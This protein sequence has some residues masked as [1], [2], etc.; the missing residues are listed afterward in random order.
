MKHEEMI[1]NAQEC[2]DNISPEDFLDEYLS[3]QHDYDGVGI[4]VSELLG[5]KDERQEVLRYLKSK[6]KVVEEVL[7]AHCETY[8]EWSN[9]LKY[10]N[11]SDFSNRQSIMSRLDSITTVLDEVTSGEWF[12]VESVVTIITNG[13]ETSFC[14]EISINNI[15]E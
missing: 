8:G 1:R 2:L 9:L 7:H 12:K 4:T 6:K 13:G 14:E 10:G 15:G 11:R 5:V 3:L